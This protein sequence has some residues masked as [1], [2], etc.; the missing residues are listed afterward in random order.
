MRMKLDYEEQCCRH[1][2]MIV[3]ARLQQLQNS[4][5]EATKPASRPNTK[6]EAP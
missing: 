3:R 6:G 1:S 5:Q 4:V 2:E